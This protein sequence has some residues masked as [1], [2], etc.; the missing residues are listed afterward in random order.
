MC[1]RDR[2]RYVVVVVVV[3]MRMKSTGDLQQVTAAAAQ[4]SRLPVVHVC[5]NKQLF[6]AR[7]RTGKTSM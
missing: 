5:T 3:L 2:R 4:Y 7:A 1:I 6:A